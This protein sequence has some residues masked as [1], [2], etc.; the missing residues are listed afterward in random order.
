M[1]MSGSDFDSPPAYNHPTNMRL[2]T[3]GSQ[4]LDDH[5]IVAYFGTNVTP[6]ERGFV[7]VGD[8]LKAAVLQTWID[9]SSSTAVLF[10]GHLTARS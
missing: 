5:G 8:Q 9:N 6:G 3:L 10:W 1:T 2:G 7:K 4:F